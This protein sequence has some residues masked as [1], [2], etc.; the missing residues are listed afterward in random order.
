MGKCSDV[1]QIFSSENF[2]YRISLHKL[3]T[4]QQTTMP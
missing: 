4:K 2:K 1:D 3:K